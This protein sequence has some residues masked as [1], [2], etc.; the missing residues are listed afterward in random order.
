MKRVLV[1][2]GRG[3][4]GRHCLPQ[5]VERGFEVHALSSRPATLTETPPEVQ[6][7][8]DGVHWHAANLLDTAAV[9]AVLQT[10][11]PTHLLHLAW[12][13][14]PRRY[15][16]APENVDWLAAS[17][18]LLRTFHA[19]GGQRVVMSGSC[20]EYDWNHGWCSESV[21][22]LQPATLYGQCKH[23]LQSTL[24]AYCKQV[25][26]S[27]GWGRL[28]FLYGP[29]GHPAKIPG[30]VIESLL[31]GDP[32]LCSHGRQIRDFLH[33]ADAARGLVLQLDSDVQ[34]P[35]NIASGEPVTIRE[36]VL[37]IAD[38]LGRRDLVQFGAVPTSPHDPPLLVADVRRLRTEL[39]WQPTYSVTSGLA[40]T[41]EWRQGALRG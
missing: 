37:Q 8:P 9:N 29:H 31:R 24:A 35:V 33:I 13:T 10:I 12:I 23:A 18:H 25:G 3:F 20:A 26:L 39:A 40:A 19:V 38:Q 4:V 1:T 21:T 15:A 2:G 11:Q 14:E 22:P 36:I 17:L 41:L 16:S 34:G 5:L 30:V 32:A 27:W 28:F 6:S 7:D